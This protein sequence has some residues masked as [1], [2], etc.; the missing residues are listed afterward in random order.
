MSAYYSETSLK[1]DLIFKALSD[2]TRR[3][4]LFMLKD[5]SMRVSDIAK[6]FDM[7]LNAISKH[8]KVLENSTLIKREIK[9]R[10]HYCKAD[11]TQLCIVEKWVG[12]YSSFWELSLN[13][14]EGILKG[15]NSKHI[16]N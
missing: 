4:I 9:G 14:L 1:L 11:L 13:L 12:Q 3:S 2:P 10:V 15:R 6:Q 16:S 5:K 8:L 7:S